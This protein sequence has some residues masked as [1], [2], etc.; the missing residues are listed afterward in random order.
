MYLFRPAAQNDVDSILQLAKH[1]GARQASFPKTHQQ[2]SLH[3]QESEAA[4]R[5]PKLNLRSKQET[6][7]DTQHYFWV[8]LH[9]DQVIGSIAIE[10]STGSKEPFYSYRRETLINASYRLKVKE[11]IPVLYRSHE[12]T[13]YSQLYAITLLPEY[14]N[15]EAICLLIQGAMNYMTTHPD[16][17]CPSVLIEF[18]GFKNEKGESPL[19]TDL[20]QHFF[21]MPLEQACFH[22]STEDKALI[23]QLMP[24]H[25][26]YENLLSETCQTTLG[27]PQQDLNDYF[28]LLI[29]EGL[30]QTQHIDIFD[31]GPC[32]ASRISN[33]H[34]FNES[35]R[36]KLHDFTESVSPMII[37]NSHRHLPA[38]IS[39]TE[40]DRGS[41][42]LLKRLLAV[43]DNDWIRWSPMHQ[44]VNTSGGQLL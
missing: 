6:V 38:S 4:F 33:T 43:N 39:L 20:G 41:V 32:L 40:N 24:D 12:L 10:A 21:K 28:Q 19:W 36:I 17:F 30:N 14:R 27:E 35:A 3:I 11:R 15:H 13:G 31:G 25:P 42:H 8:I 26:L 22:A 18:P 5:L 44:K 1:Q 37:S 23:A 7:H 2:L 29:R 34:T 9:E 16:L